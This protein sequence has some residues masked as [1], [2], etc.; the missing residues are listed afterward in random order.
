LKATR[1]N[2]FNIRLENFYAIYSGIFRTDLVFIL[3][4]ATNSEGKD[5]VYI[6]RAET[7]RRVLKKDIY[8]QIQRKMVQLILQRGNSSQYNKRE[9]MS[10]GRRDQKLFTTNSHKTE[11]EVVVQRREQEVKR[12][13]RK[14][15]TDSLQT[16]ATSVTALAIQLTLLSATQCHSFLVRTCPFA[17]CIK[18]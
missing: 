13:Q 17:L 12:R 7:V 1:L 8:Q 9:T 10:G 6:N 5:D 15:H 2:S 18:T 11:T 14:T 4:S 3:G 16:F